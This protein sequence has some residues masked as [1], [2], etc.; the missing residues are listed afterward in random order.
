[1]SMIRQKKVRK[2]PATRCVPLTPIA[3]EAYNLLVAGEK[4]GEPVRTNTEGAV[5]Y[6][7]RYWFDPAVE[8]PGN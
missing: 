4:A 3:V 8:A 2:A 1:M 6:G 7:T 5:L